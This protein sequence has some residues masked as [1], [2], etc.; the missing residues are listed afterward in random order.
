MSDKQKGEF[1]KKK[2]VPAMAKTFQEFDAKKYAD[3]GCKTCHG[4]G[5]DDHS[6]KM[7]N[8]D[9]LALPG[10]DDKEAFKPIYQKNPA[11]VTFM[12]GKVM[13]QM[14]KLLGAEPFDYKNPKPDAFSCL[15]C[16]TQQKKK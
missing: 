13:P 5:A 15:G 8:P 7:P 9:I 2:V 12:G 1:M 11:M 14:A 4:K 3:F 6:F 10:P 16:H